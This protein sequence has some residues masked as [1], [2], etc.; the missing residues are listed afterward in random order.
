MLISTHTYIYYTDICTYRYLHIEISTLAN[1]YINRYPHIQIS[2]YAGIYTCLHEY[3]Q[4]STYP[5]IY[6]LHNVLYPSSPSRRG[7]G[8]L[9]CPRSP[10]SY[11]H[12]SSL[13]ESIKALPLLSTSASAECATAIHKADWKLASCAL[14]PL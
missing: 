14:L 5:D 8:P 9:Q 7:G 10:S 6:H 1:I 2:T 3:L 12:H 4:I 13:L 11:R